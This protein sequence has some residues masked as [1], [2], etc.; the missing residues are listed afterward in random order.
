LKNKFSIERIRMTGIKSERAFY[1]KGKKQWIS[2]VFGLYDGIVFKGEQLED[3]TIAE[4]NLLYLGDIYLQSLNSFYVK[5]IDYDYFK[6]LKS[7]IVSRLYEILGVKYYGLQNKRQNYICYR[8][9]KLCQLL[10]VTPHK[11]VSWLNSN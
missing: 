1:H 7:K 8:Y 9:S 10:P 3:G 2:T 11:Y 5:P 4:T 6:S